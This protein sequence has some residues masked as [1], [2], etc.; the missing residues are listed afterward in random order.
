M[1]I[2]N[3][4]SI[5]C[6]YR[7]R[8]VTLPAKVFAAEDDRNKKASPRVIA[9][10]ML[11]KPVFKPSVSFYFGALWK[12]C[13]TLLQATSDRH[14]RLPLSAGQ[15]SPPCRSLGEERGVSKWHQARAFWHGVLVLPAFMRPGWLGDRFVR[16]LKFKWTRHRFWAILG[17]V[18]RL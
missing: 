5:E 15:A 7:K 11:T 9:S 12:D 14:R 17:A 4:K 1:Y 16:C 3:F 2:S 8:W 10:K 13:E 18:Q 6:K